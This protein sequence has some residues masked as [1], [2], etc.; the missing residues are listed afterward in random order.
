M[1]SE[2][3]SSRWLRIRCEGDK[4]TVEF[5]SNFFSYFVGTANV[6]DEEFEEALNNGNLKEV[7]KTQEYILELRKG[8]LLDAFL[9]S[10]LSGLREHTVGFTRNGILVLNP[11]TIFYEVLKEEGGDKD[12]SF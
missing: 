12:N 5:L 4:K 6:C 9:F 7:S 8:K 3:S 1:S 10:M 11:L 2:S